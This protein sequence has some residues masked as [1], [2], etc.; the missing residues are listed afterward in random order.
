MTWR[1]IAQASAGGGGVNEDLTGCAGEFAWV[2]DGASPLSDDRVTTADSDARWLV[3]IIDAHLRAHAPSDE[4]PLPA[5]AEDMIREVRRA[6]HKWQA[7]PDFPPSAAFALVR[8]RDGRVDYL[9]LGDVTVVFDRGDDVCAVT[10]GRVEASNRP[11]R[12]RFDQRLAET[13]S[14]ALAIA[15]IREA[16]IDH[17][18]RSMNRE[19]GYWVVATEPVAARHALNGSVPDADVRRVALCTDG[20]SR[21]VDTFG[22]YPFWR[23]LLD[24]VGSDEDLGALV[25]ELRVLEAADPETLRHPRWTVSDDAAALIVAPR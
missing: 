5:I 18:M 2:I 10:D 17:R 14:H 8:C 13:G 15:D 24:R 6:S 9:V 25:R 23:D 1:V 16:L 19:P 22:A 20:F 21:L 3:Q 11:A 7:R 4:R 12:V